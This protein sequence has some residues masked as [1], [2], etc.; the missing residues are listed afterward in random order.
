MRTVSEVCDLNVV[1]ENAVVER[2]VRAPVR[3]RGVV[4]KR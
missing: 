2:A 1:V 3:C 4:Q